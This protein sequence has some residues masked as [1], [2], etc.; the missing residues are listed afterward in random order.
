MA[1][2]NFVS[3]AYSSDVEKL[4]VRDIGPIAE[5]MPPSNDTALVGHV[6]LSGVIAINSA[7]QDGRPVEFIRADTWPELLNDGHRRVLKASIATPIDLS[8][9]RASLESL[10]RI[11]DCKTQEWTTNHKLLKKKRSEYGRCVADAVHECP[12]CTLEN[13]NAMPQVF[14]KV[15]EDSDLQI[16]ACGVD[17]FVAAHTRISATMR[18]VAMGRVTR[19]AKKERLQVTKKA[20][21]DAMF[22]GVAMPTPPPCVSPLNLSSVSLAAFQIS[23]CVRR[24]FKSIPEDSGEF[25]AALNA[26]V[27]NESSVYLM[28]DLPDCIVPFI[29]TGGAR[30]LHRLCSPVFDF[31]VPQPF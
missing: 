1:L 27:L 14:V 7:L 22:N 18:Q 2:A 12:G 24:M 26:T 13:D 29:K 20:M 23:V 3:H 15:F 5:R 10:R 30:A 16:Q 4:L 17:H 21:R 6:W 19:D 25:L 28:L 9:C 11:D 31:D 8:I